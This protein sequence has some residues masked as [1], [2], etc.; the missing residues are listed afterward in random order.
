MKPATVYSIG[1]YS[2]AKD[3]IEALLRN[4]DAHGA[5]AF[6]ESLVAGPGQE[7]NVES[8]RASAYVEGGSQLEC[9]D[10]LEK[11]AQI[12]CKLTPHNSV[13]IS[14]NLAST[15]LEIWQLAVDQR[16][17]A[18]AWSDKRSEL[19][20]ARKLF[21]C[22]ADDESA[23]TELRLKA[24]TD[25][26]NSYDIVGRHIDALS[27]YDQALR[28]DPSFGMALGNRGLALFY[29]AP[30]M[31]PH[32]SHV[33]GEAAADLD[34]AIH[35]QQSVLQCGGQSALDQFVRLRS[36]ILESAGLD[37][38]SRELHAS[39]E[40]PYLK[41][42][43]DNRIFLHPSMACIHDQ[44]E[45]MDPIFFS[46]I[47]SSLNPD[48][49]KL[50]NEIVDAFNAVKQDYISAR[51]LA[52][53][54]FADESPIREHTRMVTRRTSFLDTLGYIR[55]GTRTG[56]AVQAHRAAVDVLDKIASFVHLYLRSGR[57]RDVSFRSL[58]YA[59]ASSNDLDQM[60]AGLIGAPEINRGLMALTDLSSDLVNHLRK[61]VQR[62]HAAT[63]RFLVIH[64]EMPGESSEW[65]E[66]TSWI[67][68]VEESLYQLRMARSAAIYLA[69][70]ID[71]HEE[72]LST[73]DSSGGLVMPWSI[74]RTDTDLMEFGG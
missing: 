15:K 18:T 48:D 73:V 51:Y 55:W 36:K 66:H 7:A 62:R 4:G 60:I 67:D 24:H 72:S 26:G 37:Q 32:Q 31:G 33:L 44:L 38:H 5:I 12:W 21:K 61:V 27:H 25:V 13:H 54:A 34:A 63:H 29:V 52:W 30:L 35:N 39:L 59:K 41:W 6:A 71:I 58:P 65:S 40:D 69:Q 8:L 57:I 3:E 42:C 45:T 28:I 68:H 56:I 47:R 74:P 10:L 43:L 14:Y 17:L 64:N 49:L 50:T 53:L 1:A 20:E 70:M 23:P 16:G 9:L 2:Q 22:V 19:H 46:G 11:G